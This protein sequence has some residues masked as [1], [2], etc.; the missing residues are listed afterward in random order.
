MKE[1]FIRITSAIINRLG[2]TSDK[3]AVEKIET[4]DNMYSALVSSVSDEIENL[5]EDVDEIYVVVAGLID[6]KNEILLKLQ[7]IETAIKE[8][9]EAK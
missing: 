8:L 7:A 5:H 4:Q 1:T 3:T 2:N 6:A 9:Q